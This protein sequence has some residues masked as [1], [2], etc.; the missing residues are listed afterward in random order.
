MNHSRII[1]N[2]FSSAGFDVVQ[3]PEIEDDY[4]NFEAL[5]I[6]EH[7]PAKAMHDTF[8]FDNGLLLRTHTSTVRLSRRSFPS[9]T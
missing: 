7:H 4:H 2:I 8:Y 5:N 9:H 6:P 3:G 1:E